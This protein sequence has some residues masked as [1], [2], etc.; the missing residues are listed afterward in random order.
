MTIFDEIRI[1]AEQ[2]KRSPYY[3]LFAEQCYQ[4]RIVITGA[5]G[6]IGTYLIYFFHQ[7]AKVQE[8]EIYGIVRHALPD[9]LKLLTNFNPPNGPRIQFL[10]LDLSQACDMIPSADTIFHTAGYGQPI[11][12]IQEPIQTLRL[13]TFTTME[14]FKH[15]VLGGTFINFS[16]SEIYNLAAPP[17]KETDIG[18]TTP[19][20]PRGQY[21]EA[22]RSGEA[23]VHAMK[24]DY[25]VKSLRLSLIYG[26]GA[27][28]GDTR[29]I[30]QFIEQALTQS[31][32]V[33]RDSGQALRTYGYI[34]DALEMIINIMLKGQSEVYNVGG[35]STTT[36][37]GLAQEISKITKC[38][39]EIPF[40]DIRGLS[41]AP[42]NVRLDLSKTLGAIDKTEDSFIPLS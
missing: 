17:F 36:I 21:I 15:L 42:S 6:L 26:P 2:F 41:S 39:V 9:H 35:V 37:A 23:I 40:S 7:F 1:F 32:I 16:S 25:N 19:Q 10:K 3:R 28:K 8:L 11:K 29:V 31:K 18:R 34:T 27:R 13:N 5:S 24:N 4:K 33:L 20:D 14:L 12:F 30:N 38:E 22:K